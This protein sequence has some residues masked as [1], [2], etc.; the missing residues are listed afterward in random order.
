MNTYLTTNGSRQFFSC[1]VT[2][3]DHLVSISIQKVFHTERIDLGVLVEK[4][5]V[6]VILSP[7]TSERR[8]LNLDQILLPEI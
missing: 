2:G 1:K 7:L 6:V 8:D 5:A 4:F 3:D